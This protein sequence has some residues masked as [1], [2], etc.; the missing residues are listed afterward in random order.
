[1]AT[2]PSRAMGLFNIPKPCDLG[3][4]ACLIDLIRLGRK[5]GASTTPSPIDRTR[6]KRR[7]E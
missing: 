1:M 6:K 2:T 3:R 4:E 7:R 5:V